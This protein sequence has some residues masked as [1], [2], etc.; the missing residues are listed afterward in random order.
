MTEGEVAEQHARAQDP[1]EGQVVKQ[2]ED[3]DL[4]KGEVEPRTSQRGE[5][6]RGVRVEG[7]GVACHAAE[8]GRRVEEDEQ[9][10]QH[11]GEEGLDGEE[12]Q[13][14]G[15]RDGRLGGPGACGRWHFDVGSRCGDL[16]R[17]RVRTPN[18][19]GQSG[20]EILGRG[21]KGR[22]L[23]RALKLPAPD[24]VLF[25]RRPMFRLWPS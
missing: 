4:D 7:D 13:A 23:V 21:K 24:L 14:V 11:D 20:G 5:Q 2:P 17:F 19:S 18:G 10:A 6:E 16:E 22:K 12:D 3:D 9:A 1:P 15:K 25:F 8:V